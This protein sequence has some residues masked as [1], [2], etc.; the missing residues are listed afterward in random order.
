VYQGPIIDPHHHLWD[1]SLGRHPWLE[2]ETSSAEDMVFGS[3][4]RIRQDYL[5]ADYLTDAGGQPIIATVHVEAGWSDDD[6]LGESRWIN[7]LEKPGGIARRQVVRVALDRPDAD[8]LLEAQAADDSVA[9]IRDIVAWHPERAKSFAQSA[10]RMDNPNW[11][12]GLKRATALGL[13]FDL[14]LYPWQMADAFRLVADF[15]DTMFI[16]NHAGSPADRSHDG[17]TLWRNGLKALARAE[18]VSI[19]ISDLVAYDNDWTIASLKPVITQCIDCFGPARSMFASDF[20][21]AGLHATFAEIYDAF[22]ILTQD[23]SRDEQH[24]L[25]FST[26]NRTYG[27][28]LG[29]GDSDEV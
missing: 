9:G 23:L 24:Q 29:I 22:R 15:P 8:R 18:N 6:P 16:L 7:A 12:Q 14:M 19:K 4:D 1:L 26:A 28:D 17:M 21:V 2:K 3:I 11:R 27:L 13:T 10:D 5:P 20:P 25:F